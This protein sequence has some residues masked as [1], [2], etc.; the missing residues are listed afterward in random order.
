MATGSA[1]GN[2]G[3]KTRS[4]KQSP[5]SNPLPSH[6]RGPAIR[7]GR[8]LLLGI[9]AV[10]L[11]FGAY[12]RTPLTEPSDTNGFSPALALSNAPLKRLTEDVFQ[13][14]LVRFDKSKKTITFPALVN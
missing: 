1:T 5:Q 2:V 13:L 12:H 10:S 4:T 11:G 14:G 6:G 7:F 8:L 3:Q 9:T